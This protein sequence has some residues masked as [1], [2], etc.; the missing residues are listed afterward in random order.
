MTLGDVYIEMS[1]IYVEMCHNDLWWAFE[2]FF[3]FSSTPVGA[4]IE[5]RV[6]E[7]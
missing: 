5:G 3:S 2:R 6:G 7:S 4:E 1:E